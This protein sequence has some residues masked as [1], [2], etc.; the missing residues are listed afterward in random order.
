MKVSTISAVLLA[1]VPALADDGIPRPVNWQVT[2]GLVY[3]PT[4]QDGR[5]F[6]TKLDKYCKQ[7]LKCVKPSSF[8]IVQ[9]PAPNIQ[10]WGDCNKCPEWTTPKAP[11]GCELDESPIYPPA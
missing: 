1:A 11:D 9:A 6:L 4:P 7:Y 8:H 5:N 2:C 10:V 3:A